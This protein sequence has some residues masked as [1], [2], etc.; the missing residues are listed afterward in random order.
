MIVNYLEEADCAKCAHKCLLKYIKE[1]DLPILN[2]GKAELEYQPNDIVIKQGSHVAQILYVKEGLV[3]TVIEEKNKRNTILKFVP[4][5]NFIALPVLGKQKKY[6]ISV[7]SMTQSVLCLISKEEVKLLMDNNSSLLDV[8]IDWY[9]VDYMYLYSKI[10][11]LSTRNSHGK[12]ATALL[13]LADE[14][15]IGTN[16]FELVS[17]KDLADLASI[18]LESTNKILQEL[19]NER[20]IEIENRNI[21]IM[22]PKLLNTLSMIG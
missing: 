13:Y 22:K 20:I 4:P 1:D 15:F 5:G 3:K 19:K 18:S 2:N 14:Q 12:L 21:Q 7:V 11:N 17:R 8:L 16:I 9:S 6:P 10:S